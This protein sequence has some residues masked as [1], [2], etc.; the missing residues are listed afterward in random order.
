VPLGASFV[1]FFARA[2]ST[3]VSRHINKAEAVRVRFITFSARGCYLEG[4][5]REGK[6]GSLPEVG[7]R[8]WKRS[9][10]P[11]VAGGSTIRNE[12]RWSTIDSPATAGGTDR[13]QAHSRPFWSLNAEAADE[14][15]L[16][17]EC[18]AAL[19]NRHILTIG[20][21]LA[22]LRVVAEIRVEQHVA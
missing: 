20:L 13:I 17:V 14:I 16:A 18:L 1:F 12:Y 19:I 15:L 11:A 10:P 7:R 21:Q 5:L 3:D 2:I 8:C 6:R 9:V 4:P 22:R